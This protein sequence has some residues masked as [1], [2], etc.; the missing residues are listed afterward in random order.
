MGFLPPAIDERRNWLSI[1]ALAETEQ[2]E[3]AWNAL[4]HRPPYNLVRKPEIGLVMVRG[5]ADGSGAA[6]NLGEMTVTRCAAQIEDGSCGIGYV[7]G[8]RPRHA[9]LVAVFD[10]LFQNT[11]WRHSFGTA[12]LTPLAEAQSRRREQRQER[13]NRSSVDFFTMARGD[14]ES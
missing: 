6:F 11:E 2:L 7:S 4:D 12:V 14:S 10:A 3:S 1:L 13:A 5:C 9:E 8:R